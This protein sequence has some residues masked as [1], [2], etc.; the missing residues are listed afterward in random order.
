[1]QG[2]EPMTPSGETA[3][4]HLSLAT[5]ELPPELAELTDLVLDLR[6]TWSHRADAL[7]RQIDA[8]TW[9]STRNPWIILQNASTSRLKELAADAGFVAELHRLADQRRAEQQTPGWFA[10]SGDAAK[11]RGIAYLSM[12]FG[13]GEALPLYAGGLGILAGDIIKT[14]SDL[15]IPI[16]GVGLLYQEGYFRQVIDNAGWQREAYPYNEP[17]MLPIQPARADGAWLRIPLNLPGRTL[18]LRVWKVAVGRSVLYLLDSNDPLNSPAD[19]GITAK[20]YGGGS[21][22]RLM[23]E[24][25][26]G[27]AGW[28]AIEALHP[29]TEVC[30]LNEG[31]AAFAVIERARLLASRSGLHFWEAFWATRGGNVFTTHTPVEAAFDRFDAALIAKYL[32]YTRNGSDDAGAAVQDLLALGRTRADAQ[33]EPFNMAYLA[34]RGS[35]VTFGVSRLHGVVS[36]RLFQPVFSG[37]PTVEVPIGHVTN[38]VH[39]PTWD[40]AEA[41]DLWTTACGKERWRG[42]ADDLGASVDGV[43]D[44][45]LWVMRGENRCHLVESVRRRLR[46]QLAERGLPPAAVALAER[47]LDPNV[48]TLGFARRFTEYKRPNLLLRDPERLRR[49]LANQQ[50]PVQIVIAGKA[51]PEDGEGKRMI[52]EWILFAQ[53]PDCRRQLVFLDDYDLSLAQELVQGVDVWINTPRRPWEACGTSGMKVLVNG[54]LNLSVLDG[55][56]AEAWEPGLGWAI[57]DDHDDIAGGDRDQADTE[58]LYAVIEQE[59]VPAFYDRDLSGLPR[60]WLQRMRRSMASLT[61]AYATTRMIREYLSK[62]YVPAAEGLRQRLAEGAAA[63]KGMALWEQR[64]RRYWSGLHLGEPKVSHEGDAWRFLLPVYLGE[65]APED[66]RVELYADPVAGGAPEALPLTR[67]EP[68]PGSV[69]GYIYSGQAPGS[70]PAEHYT[71][72]LVPYYP[73]VRVPAEMPLILWQA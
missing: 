30:H 10:T 9:D 69:N 73:G 25:V 44:D 2:S 11:L 4:N 13:V 28:R 20:L 66:I 19:R 6:W 46:R 61:P 57:G 14:A 72:R 42:M 52:R 15:D 35:A 67:G 23:Q 48:L 8:D 32:T 1:M 3:H 54:G 18:L 17:A 58:R 26:L 38:G 55:W 5:A 64:V 45:A 71:V 27:V 21:E 60:A 33:D 41:D 12:E 62:A 34:L 65:M 36:R 68:I 37:W 16:F 39:V 49:L 53:R 56:W 22:M 29:E 43:S 51:H 50:H 70:R 40:S 59:V 24:I 7:W 31:H 47:A 63:A